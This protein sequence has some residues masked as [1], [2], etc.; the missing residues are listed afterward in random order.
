M[1]ILR[2]VGNGS[3]LDS[4]VHNVELSNISM[5]VVNLRLWFHV[6][7]L[8]AK[9]AQQHH[10]K[11]YSH[12]TKRIS[13]GSSQR[14]AATRQAQRSQRLCG[15]TK[16]RSISGGTTKQSYHIGQAD[17]CERNQH[18]RQYR[19]HNHQSEA[20]HIKSHTLV[21]QR[22]KEV[23]SNMQT[24]SIHKESQAKSLG[25]FHHRWV[26]SQANMTCQNT[27]K[28]YEGNAK[29]QALYLHIA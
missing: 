15:C 21:F 19:A 11:D 3:A 24:K 22:T 16:G 10:H 27:N 1:A 18:H 4:W 13:H 17:A 8:N 12:H 20:P 25:I 9:L 28:E 5:I 2:N 29:R 6:V 14:H 26:Y 7:A 23:W